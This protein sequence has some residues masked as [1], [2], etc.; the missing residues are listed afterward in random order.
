MTGEEPPKY[1]QIADDL[2]ARIQ[3][4]E[5]APGARLP[6]KAELMARYETALGTVDRA[7]AL[8]RTAGYIETRQGAGTFALR[9][10][11]EEPSQYEILM[12]RIEEI[13][14]EVRRLKERMTEA[15]KAAG[16]E[17]P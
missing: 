6:S 3:S 8:L 10:P 5:Y 12:G 2:R 13:A 7:L 4:G 1:R 11:D 17:P 15:E 9:P 14:D 16:V